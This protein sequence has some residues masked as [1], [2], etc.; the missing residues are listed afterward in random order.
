MSSYNGRLMTVSVRLSLLVLA[1]GIAA[2]PSTRAQSQ[3]SVAIVGAKIVDGSGNEPF[4]GTVI[5]EGGRIRTVGRS[6]EVPAGATTVEAAGRTLLPGLVDVLVALDGAPSSQAATSAL[7]ASLYSGV[8]TLGLAG[9]PVDRLQA[10]RAASGRPDTGSRVSVVGAL[11]SAAGRSETAP[12]DWARVLQS[13]PNAILIAADAPGVEAVAADARSRGLRVFVDAGSGAGALPLTPHL[14]VGAAGARDAAALVAQNVTVAPDLLVA[15]PA[16]LVGPDKI[17][18]ELSAL[19]GRAAGETSAPRESTQWDAS[20]ASVKALRD[21]RVRM[22]VASRTGVARLAPG[23]STHAAVGLLVEAGLTPLQAVTAATSG[24]AWALGLQSDRGF[25]APG[26]RAD[27]VLV[28]GDP[29]TTIA[30]LGRVERVFLG[31]VDVDRTALLAKVRPP[32]A[33]APTAAADAPAMPATEKE[34]TGAAAAAAKS[35]PARRSGRRRRGADTK[36]EPKAEPKIEAPATTPALPASSP[37]AAPAP[38]SSTPEAASAPPPVEASASAAAAAP[39]RLNAPLIDDF[40]RGDDRSAAG[41]AWSS[42][43]SDGATPATIVM[44]RV[45]RGLRDHALHLTAR[46]G[47]GRAPYARASILLTDD[48]RPVDVSRFR[49]IRFDARGEG[50]YRIVFVTRS[51]ADGRY[52]ESYFSGSPVWT[53]VGIPFASIGQNG[54]GSHASF[55]GRDLVEIRFEVA[56]DPGR[57][58]WLELDNVKF[59]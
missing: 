54:K 51:I 42:A 3:P 28:Q 52:H 14:I 33:P 6:V 17:A 59:Y 40:E 1:L 18:A 32:E 25:L 10:F 31:G 43:S 9:V 39:V 41:P 45:V 4:V 56:R 55:S 53:P 16:P 12:A 46:M 44:G 49:G 57:M 22:A 20:V 26:M 5:V 48:G 21:G 24:G 27:L 58:A 36:A 29:T 19:R 35:P 7:A 34:A 8:T 50:R 38:T 30:D 2:I 13:N 47:D 37:E 15:A 11:P 23:L